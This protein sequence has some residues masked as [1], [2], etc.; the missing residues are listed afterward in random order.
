METMFDTLLQLPLFQGLCQEDF[1]NILEK[2]KFD[3][4]KHKSGEVVIKEGDICNKLLFV[5]KGE[6]SSLGTSQTS[7]YTFMERL[8]APYL[9]EPQALFGLKTTYSAS[10]IA[11]SEVHTVSI[12]KACVLNYLFHYDIFR[13]NY[14]NIVSGRAQSLYQRLWRDQQTDLEQ[15]IIAFIT[16][17]SERISGEKIL[18]IKMKDWADYLNC[19][20]LSLSKTLHAMEK[21]NRIYLRRKE[22]IIPDLQT[23]TNQTL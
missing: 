7:L 11:D 6:F 23:L 15:R 5:I 13:L 22:I 8:E 17:H 1:T 18:K 20:R 9:I 21:E 4:T 2:V 12:S 3:F 19:T 14:L 16:E 10:Y